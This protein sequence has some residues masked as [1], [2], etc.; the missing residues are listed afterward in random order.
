M[1]RALIFN[2]FYMSLD[3]SGDRFVTFE[4]LKKLMPIDGIVTNIDL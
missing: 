3:V 1:G 2:T 4:E